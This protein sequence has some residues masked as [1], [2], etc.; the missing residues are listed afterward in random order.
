M[1]FQKFIAVSI[2]CG[3]I[4]LTVS[5]C[6]PNGNGGNIGSTTRPSNSASSSNGNSDTSSRDDQKNESKLIDYGDLSVYPI[7]DPSTWTY[8]EECTYAYKINVNKEVKLTS[9]YNS[10]YVPTEKVPDDLLFLDGFPFDIELGAKYV[11]DGKNL[12][13]VS[14][15]YIKPMDKKNLTYKNGYKYVCVIGPCDEIVS[16]KWVKIEDV[17]SVSQEAVRDAMHE[18]VALDGV[19]LHDN[20]NLKNYSYWH[21][22]NYYWVKP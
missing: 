7:S 21:N 6:A 14:K 3:C 5:S 17:D 11:W 18:T 4:I 20:G 15:A 19:L 10:K 12:R 13:Q 16:G 22:E 2:L 9:V 1:N 8:K